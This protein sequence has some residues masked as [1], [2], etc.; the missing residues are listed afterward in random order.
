M[1]WPDSPASIPASLCNTMPQEVE[2]EVLSQNPHTH[3]LKG[4][5]FH[6]EQAINSEH[7]GPHF[8]FEDQA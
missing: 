7:I 6:S 4:F 3:K 5:F 8:H 1:F 2:A